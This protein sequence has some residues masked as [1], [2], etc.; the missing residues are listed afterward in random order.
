MLALC[1]TGCG[2]QSHSQKSSQGSQGN[3]NAAF[4]FDDAQLETAQE[5][6]TENQLKYL[7]LN[8]EYYSMGKSDIKRPISDLFAIHQKLRFILIYF[9]AF[10]CLSW[11][12]V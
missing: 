1:V 3:L 9:D 4:T 10:C 7:N 8:K 11:M 2:E 5:I 12:L 6:H